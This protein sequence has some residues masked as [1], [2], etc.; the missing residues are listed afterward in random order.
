MAD[1]DA[2]LPETKERRCP[3]CQGG[4]IKPANHLL[5]LDD[6]VSKVTK[7]E[8]RCAAC[9]TAFWIVRTEWAG[10]RTLGHLRS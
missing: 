10:G 6:S 9:R 5:A 8:F 4:A 3:A 1:F 7:E 2:I